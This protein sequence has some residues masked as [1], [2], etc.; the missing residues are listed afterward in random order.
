M[1][2]YNIMYI[3]HNRFGF[4]HNMWYL[5]MVVHVFHVHVYNNNMFMIWSP[6][7]SI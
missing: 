6:F 1:L 2:Y 5:N 3:A 7:K 4:K